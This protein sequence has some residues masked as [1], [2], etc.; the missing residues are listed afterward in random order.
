MAI[1]A[2]LILAWTALSAME[3]SSVDWE[4]RVVRCGATGAPTLREAS[5]VVSVTR[6]GAEGAAR[7]EALR[8][9]MAALRG[10]SIATGRT[11]AQALDADARLASAVE[12]AVRRAR[13]AT[14]PRFF[15]DGG[16]QL[17]VEVPLDGEISEL[18]LPAAAT[19]SAPSGGAAPGSVSGVLVD[20]SAVPLA[21][22]LAPRILD[23]AGAEVYGSA[24]LGSRA[25]RGGT[26]A[27]AS[28]LASARRIFAA[29][30]GPAPRV[31]AAVR[32]EGA[33]VVVS[34]ADAAAIRGASALAEGR[35]VI[36][37]RGRP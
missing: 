25:R 4:R 18:L 24:A 32:A 36:V 11:V 3:P 27:Y 17:R 2:L 19:G 23:E 12:A 30:L 37:A 21:Y 1:R 28:D 8:S 22:A 16:V 13:S 20:A 33:D 14:E 9:C 29:R 26:A 31:V 10:V 34:A 5:D 15:S 7:R 35:V 6:V